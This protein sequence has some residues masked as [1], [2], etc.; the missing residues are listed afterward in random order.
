MRIISF[1]FLLKIAIVLLVL[2]NF[3]L[4][5]KV[6]NSND[7]IDRI[8]KDAELANNILLNNLYFQIESEDEEIDEN[9]EVKIESGTSIRYADLVSTGPKLILRYSELH[10]DM[11]IDH[12]LEYLKRIAASIGKENILILASYKSQR[13]LSI[14][15]RINKLD[16]PVYKIAK[17]GLKIPIE[18]YSIPY[19]FIADKTLHVKNL[20]ILNKDIE[21]MSEIFLSIIPQKFD[22][23]IQE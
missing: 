23:I 13:D 11:C 3:A 2:M 22:A 19:V 8:S 9:I 7:K 21:E 4:L 6:K 12:S 20:H 17:S 18:Q 5:I 1:S 10:C 14:F 15:K 16:F